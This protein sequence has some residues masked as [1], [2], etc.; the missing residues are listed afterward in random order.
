MEVLVNWLTMTMLPIADC[1]LG[2]CEAMHQSN[3]FLR[4]RP[5]VFVFLVQHSSSSMTSIP[6]IIRGFTVSHKLGDYM[7]FT[8]RSWEA[9]AKIHLYITFTSHS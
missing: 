2:M 1:S 4:S 6:V 5:G 8:Q 7:T 3:E 9:A